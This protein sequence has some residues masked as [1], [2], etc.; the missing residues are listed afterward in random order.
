MLTSHRLALTPD[1][2]LPDEY[3][4]DR[5]VQ[6]LRFRDGVVVRMRGGRRI[7]VDPGADLDAFYAVLY[8]TVQAA[9]AAPD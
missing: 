1:N 3:R 2:G 9:A 5:V 7:Y 4:L 6:T 8:R